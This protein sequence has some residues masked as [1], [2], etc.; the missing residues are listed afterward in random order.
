M[1]DP[2]AAGGKRAI[3]ELAHP[4]GQA[5]ECRRSIAQRPKWTM[6]PP[7][8]LADFLKK[9]ARRA[10]GATGSDRAT[11]HFNLIHD[12]LNSSNFADCF[13]RELRVK[14][15]IQTTRNTRTPLSYA[16]ATSRS[17]GW[18]LALRRALAIPATSKDV[19]F[20]SIWTD[21]DDRLP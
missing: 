11:N 2:A 13:L 18:E 8:P 1:P 6:I 10:I 9:H 17:A 7:E 16:Q 20:C 19:T 5:S 15:T 12:A 14:E 21:I 3:I 4:H